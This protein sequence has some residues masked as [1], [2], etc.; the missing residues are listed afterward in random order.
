VV[1][2]GDGEA[3]SSNRAQAQGPHA[4]LV[5]RLKSKS[6][7]MGVCLTPPP[8]TGCGDRSVAEEVVTERN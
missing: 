6:D 3:I 4:D 5:A 2:V 1:E 8:A 7:D